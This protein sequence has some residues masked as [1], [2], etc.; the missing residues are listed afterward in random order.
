[1]AP[2][3]VWIDI[4]DGASARIARWGNRRFKNFV[5]GSHIGRY[6]ED[7]AMEPEAN[8]EETVYKEATARHIL[9]DIR[10]NWQERV[11]NGKLVDI[12]FNVPNMLRLFNELPEFYATIVAASKEFNDY[13]E[14]FLEETTGNLIE[15]IRW[16]VRWAS[17]LDKFQHLQESGISIGAMENRPTLTPYERDIMGHFH[18][19]AR[20]VKCPFPFTELEAYCRLQGVEDFDEREELVM[21]MVR[22]ASALLEEQLKVAEEKKEIENPSQPEQKDET[23]NNRLGQ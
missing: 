6:L 7:T 13:R 21:Y 16:D 11:G 3:S 22:M 1:M 4:A 9:L 17:Q 23:S 12:E 8:V 19:I 20:M 5:S 15:Y 2:V 10:G 14:T 18:T